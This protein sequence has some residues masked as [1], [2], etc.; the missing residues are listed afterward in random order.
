M[1]APAPASTA[2]GTSLAARPAGDAAVLAPA[3]A[4]AATAPTE[5]ASF[6]Q[7]YGIATSA[8]ASGLQKSAQLPNTAKFRRADEP[9]SNTSP[10]LATFQL[11]Q[12]G[13]Q[14]RVIDGDGSTYVGA[15]TP[16]P[17]DKYARKVELESV[18]VTNTSDVAALGVD[19][20][21]KEFGKQAGQSY[22]FRVAG[23]NRTLQQPVVFTGNIVVLTNAL[24]A[25]Q[26]VLAQSPAKRQNQLAPQQNQFPSLLNSTVSGNVQLGT[27]R[28]MKINAVPVNP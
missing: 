26:T 4:P 12:A 22:T 17:A 27:N 2:G 3:T 20:T 8:S 14:L 23:T 9:V 16:P 13:D 1:V 19:S 10:V 25:S 7:R 6:H 15:L 5:A 11:E 28:E 24:P 18:S 21:A